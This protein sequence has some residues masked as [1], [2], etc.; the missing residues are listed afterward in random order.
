MTTTS[1][2]RVTWSIVLQDKTIRTLPDPISSG[3]L[4]KHIYHDSYQPFLETL[5]GRDLS[6]YVDFFFQRSPVDHSQLEFVDKDARLD[7]FDLLKDEG[8]IPDFDL[9][10]TGDWCRKKKEQQQPD[11]P[12]CCIVFE[13][14]RE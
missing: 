11:K 8:L 7:F 9:I 6:S 10:A 12:E 14:E 1:F 13:A 2:T 4:D 5:D 3:L